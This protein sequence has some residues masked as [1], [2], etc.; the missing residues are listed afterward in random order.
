VKKLFR[1]TRRRTWLTIGLTQVFVRA[2]KQ[3]KQNDIQIRN[4]IRKKK[5]SDEKK[6]NLEEVKKQHSSHI[7]TDASSA[8]TS[9]ISNVSR[10]YQ[11]K[12][13]GRKL[14]AIVVA[15]VEDAVTVPAMVVIVVA[16]LA[17]VVAAVVVVAAAA[18]L[19]RGAGRVAVERREA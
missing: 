2:A 5:K 10:R 8:F 16:V 1:L 13:I 9:D 11:K 15:T 3:E 7:R 14:A 18:C 6:K 12:N 19:S 4:D 17:V